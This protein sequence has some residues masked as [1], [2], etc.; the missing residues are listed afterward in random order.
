[1]TPM[2][3]YKKGTPVKT[4]QV[5]LL[6]QINKWQLGIGSFISGPLLILTVKCQIVCHLSENL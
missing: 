5:L 1:M 4:P 6:Q 2:L 3:K